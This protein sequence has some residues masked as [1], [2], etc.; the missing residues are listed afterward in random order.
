[1]QFNNRN[2]GVSY[3]SN[4][5]WWKLRLWEMSRSMWCEAYVT[6]TLHNASFSLS[7][8][9]R[10]KRHG[11][12]WDYPRDIRPGSIDM[13][14]MFRDQPSR[15]R[16]LGS[17][18]ARFSTCSKIS[19]FPTASDRKNPYITV[20]AGTQPQH[21]LC[22]P[23]SETGHK[24]IHFSRLGRSTTLYPRGAS[25]VRVSLMVCVCVCVSHAGIV[26]KQLK[27]G[28]RKQRHVIAHRL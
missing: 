27:V 6:L 19:Y 17:S 15:F 3:T 8:F 9:G 1:M 20:D 21:I 22:G 16:R 5:N 11:F 13:T 25:D 18:V 24:A 28:S 14:V 10:W 7:R 2:A 4:T 12:I 23:W 26:S